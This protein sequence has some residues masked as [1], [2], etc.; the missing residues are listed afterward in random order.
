MMTNEWGGGN[1]KGCCLKKMG[2]LQ[3]GPAELSTAEPNGF[4]PFEVAVQPPLLTEQPTLTLP[5]FGGSKLL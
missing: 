1:R 4:L 5:Q 2:N 3:H